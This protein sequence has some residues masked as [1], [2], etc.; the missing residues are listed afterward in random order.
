MNL[1]LPITPTTV[2][3]GQ[4]ASQDPWQFV[5]S[6]AAATPVAPPETLSVLHVINGEHF[7]GAER[8]QQLLGERLPEFGVRA[9]FACLKPGKF[10]TH[11]GLASDRIHL[12]PMQSRFDLRESDNSRSWSSNEAFS[13]CMRT[14]HEPP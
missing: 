13:F 1:Q 4:P 12:H 9:E 5:H 3:C 10:P 8:V 11:C 6:T 7:S 14:L 2:P